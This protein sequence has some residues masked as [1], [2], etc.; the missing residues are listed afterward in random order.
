MCLLGK[1][2]TPHWGS[3]FYLPFLPPTPSSQSQTLELKNSSRALNLASCIAFESQLSANCQL[4]HTRHGVASTK[5]GTTDSNLDCK[6]ARNTPVFISAS[7]GGYPCPTPL[8][9]PL[10][11]DNYCWQGSS[12]VLLSQTSSRMLEMSSGV[13][14][15][16]IHLLSHGK[17]D[18]KRNEL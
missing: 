7:I 1:S 13:S 10:S 6:F 8:Y 3:T 15:H 16:N 4:C 14:C 2:T 11:V 12:R 9:T 18:F 5:S 17:S